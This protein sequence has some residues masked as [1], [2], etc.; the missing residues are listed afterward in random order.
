MFRRE[1]CLPYEK[2]YQNHLPGTNME[3]VEAH[4]RHGFSISEVKVTVLPYAREFLD[5]LKANGCKLYVLSSMCDKAFSEQVVALGLDHYFERTYAGV[6]DKREVIGQMMQTHEMDQ[7][8]TVFVGDMTH[9]VETAH[10]VGIMS[11]GVL[12]G[13]N[14]AAVLAASEPSIL[15]K[16]LALLENLLGASKI[17]ADIVKIRGLE[18]PTFIGVPDDEREDEQVLKVNIDM[19]PEVSFPLLNDEIEGGVDYYQVSLR[20]KEVALEKPRKLI[21]TLAEDLARVVLEEFSVARVR[22]EIE[23]FILPDTDHVGVEIWR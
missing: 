11:V 23:K 17:S 12:T 9:D 1:F 14:H 16:D 6:L 13:Y 2:F 7:D 22:V 4:F 21:E 5:L 3:E 18:I 19:V 10:H 20:L 15:V 8:D